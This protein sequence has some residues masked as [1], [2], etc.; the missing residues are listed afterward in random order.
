MFCCNYAL[1]FNDVCSGKFTPVFFQNL[2]AAKKKTNTEIF[3]IPK[4][5]NFSLFPNKYI[6]L[7][8]KIYMVLIKICKS[9]SMYEEYLLDLIYHLSAAI[10][11]NKLLIILLTNKNLIFFHNR[12]VFCQ[13][14]KT[15]R[16][17]LTLPK[18]SNKKRNV[19]ITNLF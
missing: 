11:Q 5:L 9:C 3:P 2:S 14:W 6:Y 16:F 17:D 19:L 12:Y 15:I 18:L 10:F 4:K 7:F 13:L 1:L 8:V